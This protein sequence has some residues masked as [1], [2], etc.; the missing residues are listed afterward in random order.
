MKKLLNTLF[1]TTQGSY[2]FKEGETVVIKAD[3]EIRLR[4]P[5][6]YTRRDCLLWA[7]ILQSI[8]HGILC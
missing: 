6:S 4:L 5:Y 2:L 8:P 7:S 1:V 3:D